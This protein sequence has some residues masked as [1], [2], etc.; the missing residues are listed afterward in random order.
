M[1]AATSPGALRNG[2]AKAMTAWT[3][4][5]GHQRSGDGRRAPARRL[6]RAGEE[7][8]SVGAVMLVGRWD[9]GLGPGPPEWA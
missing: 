4:M 8:S 5:A 7:V 2:N 9:R 6:S 1:S 3:T